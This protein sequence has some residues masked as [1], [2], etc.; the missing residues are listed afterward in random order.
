MEI[1]SPQL[2][3]YLVRHGEAEHN[4]KQVL[5]SIVGDEVYALTPRGRE[6]ITAVAEAIASDGA[7]DAILS[8]P[9]PRTRETA[10]LIAEK[11][12]IEKVLYDFRLRETDFGQW[13][14]QPIQKFFEKY[15]TPETRI[16]TDGTDGVESFLSQRDRCAEFLADLKE[17]YLG[18]RVVIVSHGDTLE[19]LHGLIIGES[20]SEAAMGWSPAKGEMIKMKY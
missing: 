4:V 10:G 7:I 17:H 9:M 16:E 20:V 12:G 15:P 1:L 6:Q 19:Q 14:G 13:E 8:S 3:L 11:T 2:T 5:D 18:K